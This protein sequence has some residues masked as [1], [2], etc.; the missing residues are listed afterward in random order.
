M[1]RLILEP[2]LCNDGLIL[3]FMNGSRS[4][5]QNFSLPRF[6]QNKLVV[7]T[8]DYDTCMVDYRQRGVM[9]PILVETTNA[10]PCIV[11]ASLATNLQFMEYLFHQ[12]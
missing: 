10:T 7:F 12:L 6:S 3:N 1:Q 9:L 5:V 11:F 4:H 8:E 2:N